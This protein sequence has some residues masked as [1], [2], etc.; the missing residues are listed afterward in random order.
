MLLTIGVLSRGI[1]HPAKED[2]HSTV[3]AVPRYFPAALLAIPTKSGRILPEAV[4]CRSPSCSTGFTC[5]NT[6]RKGAEVRR[7]RGEPHYRY[8]LRYHSREFPKS[9]PKA[10]SP[11]CTKF[12]SRERLS[13]LLGW[14]IGTNALRLPDC[15]NNGTHCGTWLSPDRGSERVLER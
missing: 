3:A 5:M 15:L 14:N 11:S 1:S 12:T 13:S 4:Q 9:F 2:Q 8:H 6:T 7:L 10:S